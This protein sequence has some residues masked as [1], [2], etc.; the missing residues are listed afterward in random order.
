MIIGTADE[1]VP[2]LDDFIW[3]IVAT[4]SRLQLYPLEPEESWVPVTDAGFIATQTVTQILSNDIAS[5]INAA[6]KFG[7]SASEFW[8]QVNSE[9]KHPCEPVRWAVWVERALDDTNQVGESHPLWPVQ[10]LLRGRER[11]S[12]SIP[13]PLSPPNRKLLCEAVKANVRYLGRVG[14]LECRDS[15]YPKDQPGIL[16]RS[17]AAQPVPALNIPDI[18]SGL[19]PSHRRSAV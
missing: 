2:N 11:D 7:L 16:H 10:Q 15:E 5:Y 3:R 4:A 8:A 9:L 13:S 19:N 17:T 1:G 18:N 14:Y 12:I 6:S